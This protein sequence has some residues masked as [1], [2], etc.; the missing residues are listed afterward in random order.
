[1][2]VP[3]FGS[4]TVWAKDALT[5]DCLSTGL[6]VLGPD[7]ALDWATRQSDIEI[8]VLETTE[9]GLKARATQG[10]KNYID[11]GESGIALLFQ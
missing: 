5:A 2:L 4:L 10:F 11:T 8:L 1:M 6:Y 7:M 3:D 9:K